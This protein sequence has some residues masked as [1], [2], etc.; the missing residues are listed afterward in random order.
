MTE[1]GDRW[2]RW[3]GERRFGG[4]ETTRARAFADLLIPVRDAVLEGA[5]PIAAA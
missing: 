5:E 1:S 2:A 3:L 4:D